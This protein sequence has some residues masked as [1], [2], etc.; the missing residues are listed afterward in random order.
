MRSLPR[1]KS[2]LPRL[3]LENCGIS[4]IDRRF[5]PGRWPCCKTSVVG[6][7]AIQL[8]PSPR[9]FCSERSG[10]SLDV[11]GCLLGADILRGAVLVLVVVL[12]VAVL[13]V[14]ELVVVVVLL[15]AGLVLVLGIVAVSS[16][17]PSLNSS[18]KNVSSIHFSFAAC[19]QRPPP[20]ISTVPTRPR[21]LLTVAVETA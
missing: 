2:I 14:V 12:L 21:L 4:C 11:S 7:G 6:S 10:H 3:A 16:S 18:D 5:P 8:G 17:L 19:C 20:N 1:T 15:V 13:V 9:L